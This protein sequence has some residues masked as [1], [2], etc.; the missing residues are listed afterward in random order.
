MHVFSTLCLASSL[1]ALVALAGPVGRRS[2]PAPLLRARNADLVADKYIVV[3]NKDVSTETADS[4]ETISTYSSNADRFYNSTIR[5]FAGAL[6]EAGIEELRNHSGVSD[7]SPYRRG[8]RG[9]ERR[10]VARVSYLVSLVGDRRPSTR[11]TT[12]FLLLSSSVFFPGR[13]H[14]AGRQIQ[15]SLVRGAG[16]RNM[17][18]LATLAP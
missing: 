1:S 12:C 11:L 15:A 6:D 16:G 14:R 9:Q 13:L 5:G 2:A 4:D 7:R 17:R 18:Y 3:M 8:A 10:G